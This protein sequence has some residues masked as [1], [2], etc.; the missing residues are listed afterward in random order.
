MNFLLLADIVVVLHFGFVLFVV[1]GFLAILMG[2][3][4]KWGWVRNRRYRYAH[5]G[6]MLFVG[7]E[8]AIGMVCPLTRWENELRSAAGAGGEHGAFIA[9]MVANLLYYDFPQWVFTLVYLLLAG[10]ALALLWIVPPHR[11]KP[12]LKEHSEI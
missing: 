7:V 1:S 11:R 5:V 4:L 2:T 6:A 3:P 12:T 9:R 10:F 8:A